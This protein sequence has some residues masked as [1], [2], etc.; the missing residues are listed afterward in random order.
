MEKIR[1]IERK[2]ND[3]FYF[4]NDNKIEKKTCFQSKSIRKNSRKI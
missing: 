4:F 3:N 1:E 2:K